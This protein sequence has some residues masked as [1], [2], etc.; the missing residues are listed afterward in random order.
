MSK[1]Y[2]V[3][4]PITGVIYVEVE[5]ENE[6][7]AINLAMESEDLTLKAVEE[8][9]PHRRVVKGNVFCG[10]AREATLKKLNEVE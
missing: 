5:A 8:W 6:D 2:V 1:T 7:E 9:E 4:V 3:S 10:L